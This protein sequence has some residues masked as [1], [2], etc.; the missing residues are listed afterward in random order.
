MLV[1][2]RKKSRQVFQIRIL[3]L[4]MP[5]AP[6]SIL[7][8]FVAAAAAATTT[9]TTT[10]R[11]PSPSGKL[12]GPN[13]FWSFDSIFFVEAN[14]AFRSQTSACRQC[15]TRWV[16]WVREGSDVVSFSDVLLLKG[17]DS[18]SLF[19]DCEDQFPRITKKPHDGSSGC[20]GIYNHP[21]WILNTIKINPKMQV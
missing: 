6:T 21:T 4:N 2:V 19:G 13:L 1:C 7:G 10:T 3:L 20:M 9:T 12:F 18:F 11:P 17:S 15:T 5:Y 16:P 14:W 8:L